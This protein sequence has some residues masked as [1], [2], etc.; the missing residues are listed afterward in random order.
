M[1]ENFFQ[2]IQEYFPN[3][4]F[5]AT[6]AYF[7][8]VLT[9]ELANDKEE[10]RNKMAELLGILGGGLV[11][12]AILIFKTIVQGSSSQLLGI[13]S[14][15]PMR[16]G[17][18]GISMFGYC[19]QARKKAPD[20]DEDFCPISSSDIQVERI[21]SF[22]SIVSEKLPSVADEFYFVD[23]LGINPFMRRFNQ[24][25]VWVISD[26]IGFARVR[27]LIFPDYLLFTSGPLEILFWLR[28]FLKRSDESVES[29]HFVKELIEVFYY[30]YKIG[31]VSEEQYIDWQQRFKFTIDTGVD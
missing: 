2:K 18:L 17:C 13:N 12:S 20:D 9:C 29:L 4:R 30:N 23:K 6:G 10:S 8:K 16:D 7:G 5:R 11:A 31:F 25:G 1:N 19:L 26:N 21:N 28:E 14:A 15:E 3:L 24:A 27:D 22:L